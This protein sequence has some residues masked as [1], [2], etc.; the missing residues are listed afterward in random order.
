MNQAT[1]NSQVNETQYETDE[2]D[3]FT[4]RS[5]SRA[6]VLSLVFAFFGLLAWISPILLFLAAI[7]LVFGIVAI[8]N[9]KKYPNELVG[10]PVAWLG[11]VLSGA[12]MIGAPAR[13]IYIYNTEVPEGFERVSFSVLNSR[14]GEPDFPTNEAIALNGKKVFIKGYVHP[15]SI[16]SNSSKSFVL[17]PDL[18][19][20]CF[21]TQPPLTHMIQVKLVN[22]GY[23]Y[24]SLRLHA[25]A[26]TLEVHPHIKPVE[27]LEGVFYEFEAE[28]FQ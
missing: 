3:E 14:K 6:A 13:H 7:G 19:T 9:L 21:G 22:D 26:G 23:A 16:S 25:I 1:T 17:I 15:T 8:R 10:T 28:H 24:K 2:S 12:I 11:L 4:Y 5:L 27:G 18:G 20:C